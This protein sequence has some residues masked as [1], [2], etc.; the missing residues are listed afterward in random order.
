MVVLVN[1]TIITMEKGLNKEQ[2]AK[3]EPGIN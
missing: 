1:P 2:S 3:T